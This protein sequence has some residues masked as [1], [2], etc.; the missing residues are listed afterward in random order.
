MARPIQKSFAAARAALP[1]GQW[2]RLVGKAGL[3][4]LV[5]I[6]FL[7]L[8]ANRLS[9]MPLHETRGH[10]IALA[11]DQ[12][13]TAILATAASFWAVGH[14]DGVIH[15][16]LATGARPVD[17]RR[18]GA[19]AIAVSQTLG[20]GVITGAIL[21]W[22]MLPDQTLWQAAKITTLV[23]VFFLFGWAV[24]TAT[25]LAILPQAPFKPLA[26]G[27]LVICIILILISAIAPRF[28]RFV[29][30][31]L[32]VISRLL[33]LAAI[34]TLT[35]AVALWVLCPPDLVLPFATLLPAFLV[36]LGAGLISGTPG[37]V[38]AFEIT[39]LAL[40]PN[41]P[42]ASLLA[43]ILAW[44]AVYFALPAII[45]AGMAIRGPNQNRK[46]APLVPQPALINCAHRAEASL[47]AQG[48]LNLI[49][50]GY[51][52]AW[53][54]G[55]T[56]HCLVA[57]LD[58][59]PGTA[60]TRLN[61]YDTKRAIT[62]LIDAAKTESRLPILYKCTAR[63]AIAA[64]QLGLI[65]R[66]IAREAW[67]DPSAFALD[68]PSRAGLR[69]K[70]R[71]A[72]QSGI[73]ITTPPQN[74]DA[75]A[76]INAEWIACHGTERG[77][78]MGRFDR[79]YHQGQRVYVASF[80]NKPVAFISLHTGKDEWTLD[81]M[82]HTAVTPDGTMQALI[83]AAV[84]D[85]AAQDIPRLSLSAV[86]LASLTAAPITRLANLVHRFLGGNQTGLAQFKSSFVPNWQTLYLAAPH[87][88][89]LAIAGAEIAREVHF[90][91]PTP[92]TVHHDHAEYE[93]ASQ[94]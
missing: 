17:A 34:D 91:P 8:L 86:P 62:A 81:L 75:L 61:G 18:A 20:L 33:A 56:P 31:N 78:S 60:Q 94:V 74:W 40:L 55:R 42:E 58:P 48:H 82:R 12:W 92:S 70:L 1:P 30:P 85:A 52:Q 89:G 38:G 29:W 46:L 69:R 37:G 73:A 47:S 24:I 57:L 64:R 36:A 49:S 63:T 44:R 87:R 4:G 9:D 45:G 71:R 2:R 66:P 67:L 13:L 43:A 23:A 50:A 79:R 76:Q 39:L 3:A 21:R 14:Y 88:P 7:W 68:S 11:P 19:T 90:P 65:L 10:F 72:A 6:A 32:F 5:A 41:L 27:V 15:R 28:H 77:F 59:I 54:A 51:D 26:V 83:A 93:I 16:Y 25:V 80:G 84:T 53:L 35:A 22:R